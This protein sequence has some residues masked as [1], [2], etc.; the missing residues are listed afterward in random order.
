MAAWTDPET[1]KLIEL[2][3]DGTIQEDLEGCKK[4]S[5]I[6]ARLSDQM[7]KA[8]YERTLV[9]CRDKIKKLK[10]DYRK[11]KD[12]HKQ[13]GNNRKKSN[14]FYEKMNEVMS[15]KHSV[16]P[17]FILDTSVVKSSIDDEVD[18]IPETDLEDENNVSEN[19]PKEPSK[20][21]DVT[22]A[23]VAKEDEE[24][25]KPKLAGSKRKKSAKIDKMEKVIDKMCEKISS[26]QTE[27]DR[28]YADL[29]EKRMKIEQDMLKMQQ[30]MQREQIERAERQRREERDFQL[31]LFGMLCGQRPSMTSAPVFAGQYHRS[32]S[33]YSAGSSESGGNCEY[34]DY[35]GFDYNS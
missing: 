11:I 23:L 14:K 6:Y 16:N 17:P 1:F 18:E 9:Q 8:G 29:E 27:S 20:D 3:G 30:D 10:G 4:N 24:D 32:P 7:Q 35:Q 12:G 19:E 26:Q 15:A 33:A 5:Q 2:W 34:G 13:T 21:G 28:V 22:T 31:Q 25:V